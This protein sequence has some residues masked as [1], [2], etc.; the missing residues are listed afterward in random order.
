[1]TQVRCGFFGKNT[2]KGF[3]KCNVSISDHCFNKW[4]GTIDGKHS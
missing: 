4:H 2:R 1:M 3:S